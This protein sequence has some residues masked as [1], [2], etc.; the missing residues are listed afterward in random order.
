MS[1]LFWS[2]IWQ[3]QHTYTHKESLKMAILWVEGLCILTL[4]LYSQ[5]PN[6]LKELCINFVTW[7][8]GKEGSFML[9]SQ[10][11]GREIWSIHTVDHSVTK[12]VKHW[13]SLHGWTLKTWGHRRPR[14]SRFHTSEMCRQSN[15]WRMD[16][17]LLGW[18]MEQGCFRRDE[19]L[20]NH[21]VMMATQFYEHAKNHRTVHFRW[22]NFMATWNVF[23]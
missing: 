4:P 12:W 13:H 3:Y 2:W 7:N 17:R 14:I 19:K 22:V 6:V 15:P 1:V 9:K 23:Q 20:Q 18:G 11:D 10:P 21:T 8:G 16:S 5:V